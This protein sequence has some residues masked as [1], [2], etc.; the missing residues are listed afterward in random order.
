MPLGEFFQ[1]YNSYSKQLPLA[2][3]IKADGLQEKL[4]LELTKFNIKNY[5]VFDMSVPDGLACLK[6]GL[7]T[8]TRQSEYESNPAFYEQSKGV[9]LDEF[10]SHWIDEITV[11]QHLNNGKDICIVSPELHKR[12]MQIEWNNYKKFSKIKNSLGKLMICTDLP[13]KAQRMFNED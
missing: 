13:E 9:W 3:N 11:N 10:S 2:L 1:I 4:L 5:F 7:R 12:S 6:A 8:F